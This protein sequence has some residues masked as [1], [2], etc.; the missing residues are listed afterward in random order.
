MSGFELTPEELRSVARGWQHQ[1]AAIRALNFGSGLSTCASSASVSGLA[2]CT[3]AATESTR[4]FAD[5]LHQLGDGVVR[6]AD[7]AETCDS[8]SATALGEAAV[9]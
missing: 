6:F 7:L 8:A 5:D 9:Q 2:A 1:G 3:V 4:G